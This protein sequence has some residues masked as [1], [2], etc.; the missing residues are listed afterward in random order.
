M[1]CLCFIYVIKIYVRKRALTCVAKNASVE[2]KLKTDTIEL[3]CKFEVQKNFMI[4]YV[5][6]VRLRE[7]SALLG[8]RLF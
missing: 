8:D 4:C 3:L 7:M 6:C 2:I 1:S 5:L